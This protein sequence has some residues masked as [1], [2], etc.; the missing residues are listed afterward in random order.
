ME[1]IELFWD[2][3]G[4]DGNRE[5]VQRT[6]N[7][8]KRDLNSSLNFDGSELLKR[9]KLGV[10][11]PHVKRAAPTEFLVCAVLPPKLK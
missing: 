3:Y 11:G 5:S 8:R 1:C 4:N 7:G 9:V 10:T 6:D 2:C